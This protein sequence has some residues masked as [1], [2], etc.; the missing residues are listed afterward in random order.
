MIDFTLRY[1]N[2]PIALNLAAQFYYRVSLIANQDSDAY[3]S[4]DDTT[5]EILVEQSLNSLAKVVV[6]YADIADLIGNAYAISGGEQA[7]IDLR[8]PDTASVLSGVVTKFRCVDPVTRKH[9]ITFRTPFAYLAETVTIQ[10]AYRGKKKASAIVTDILKS[11]FQLKDSE[12]FVEES[13]TELEDFIVPNWTI[14]ELTNWMKKYVKP[15]KSRNAYMFFE[16]V[17]GVYFASFDA[18]FENFAS[19]VRMYEV[20][21]GENF[22]PNSVPRGVVFDDE[23]LNLF[24]HSMNLEREALGTTMECFDEDKKKVLFRRRYLNDKTLGELR[25]VGKK[26]VYRREYP[27]ILADKNYAVHNEGKHLLEQACYSEIGRTLMSSH[28]HKIVV[29][30]D[31]SVTPGTIVA[32]RFF[33]KDGS[34]SI[35][36]SGA[37]VVGKVE[38]HFRLRG[39]RGDQQTNNECFTALTIYRDS[40]YDVPEI[41]S[42]MN[43]LISSGSK[44]VA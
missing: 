42:K 40:Y 33:N 28:V 34:L 29:L 4:L 30:P 44:I 6:R 32:V 21:L 15:A 25:T 36:K 3:V 12:F 26:S 18:L 20:N 23:S 19:E 17:R 1:N 43:N 9:D 39:V 10:R 41:I 8:T 5:E 38:H 7:L 27:I 11:V 31:M 24:D 35:P 13:E 14:T 37:W 22:N 2:H 16:S